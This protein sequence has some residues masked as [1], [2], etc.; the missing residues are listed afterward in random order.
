MRHRLSGISIASAVALFAGAPAALGQNYLI[1]AAD[2]QTNADSVRDALIA[3]GLTNVT[4][5]AGS[6]LVAP[7][8]AELLAYDAVLTWTNQSYADSAAMGDVLADYTDAGG[9]VVCAVYCVSTTTANRSLTGRWETGVYD[10]IPQRSGNTSTTADLG[11]VHLPAHPLWA[12]MTTF[13]GDATPARSTTI[14]VTSHG[15]RIADWTTGQVLAAASS[16][17]PG[18]VDL[19]FFPVEYDI[20]ADG[21]RLMANALTY[22][23]NAP[24]PSPGGC[25]FTDG[26]CAIVTPAN[27]LPMGGV[28]RGPG[29]DCVAACPQPAACCF[30][31]GSCAVILETACTAQGGVFNS[32]AATCAAPCATGSPAARSAGPTTLRATSTT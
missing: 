21:V 12:G 9:G 13:I 17:F 4:A 32:G 19:N 20:H 15:L 7:T 5:I 26:T 18:R 1:L 31:D 29:T 8:L 6:G 22:A 11:T 28:F 2:S 24:A 14:D 30:P 27:C 3:H 16:T 10:I 25:C 23:G